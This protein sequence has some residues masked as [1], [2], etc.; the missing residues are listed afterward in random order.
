MTGL[1]ARVTTSEGIVGE[2]EN[3]VNIVELEEGC[4]ED[5]PSVTTFEGLDTVTV[6]GE[7]MPLEKVG[8]VETG[9]R[10]VLAGENGIAVIGTGIGKGE[11]AYGE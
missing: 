4:E 8:D 1:C 7:T 6:A 11:E 5:G 10:K 2:G 3:L 9:L